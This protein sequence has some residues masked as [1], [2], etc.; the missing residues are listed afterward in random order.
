[1]RS[2]S[3]KNVFVANE[4]KSTENDSTVTSLEVRASFPRFV[5]SSRGSLPFGE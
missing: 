5:F 1:M 2:L 4:A 3:C